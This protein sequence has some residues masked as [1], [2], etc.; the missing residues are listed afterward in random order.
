MIDGRANATTRWAGVSEVKA[1]DR[2]ARV[3]ETRLAFS[4]AALGLTQAV[5]SPKSSKALGKPAALSFARSG[6]KT[7]SL[8]RWDKVFCHHEWGRYAR[9]RHGRKRLPRISDC[10]GV[11][12]PRPSCAGAG[13]SDEPADQSRSRKLADRGRSAGPRF[14]GERAKRRSPAFPFGRRLP[15]L[16]SKPRRDRPE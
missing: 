9:P 15:S 3:G 6:R 14:A 4:K 7:E 5:L 13:A 10:G 12:R 11:A 16:G 8:G 1:S 2:G